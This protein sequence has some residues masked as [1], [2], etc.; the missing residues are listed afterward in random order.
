MLV[1]LHK[2]RVVMICLLHRWY[3]KN[4]PER[5]IMLLA[6]LFAIPY[7]LIA[8]N[9]GPVYNR[10]RDTN[11]VSELIYPKLVNSFYEL[12]GNHLFWFLS[13]TNSFSLRQL[14]KEKIDSSIN[15]GLKKE[16]Y[17]I[18]EI[19][20]YIY[21]NFLPADSITATRIEWIFTDAAIAY[22]KD[23]YQGNDIDQWILSDELSSKQE[24]EDNKF[25]LKELS[26]VNSPEDLLVLFNL[27]E[28]CDV[29]YQ[30]IKKELQFKRDS[31]TS[32]QKKQITTSLQVYRWMHHFKFEKW[33]IVNIASATLRYY[34]YDSIKLRMKAVVGKPST[35]TP[36]IATY[37][38]Y[39]ILYP[40]WNVPASIALNELLPEFKANPED[41]DAL[42]MQV[43][44]LKGNIVDHHK[45][46][47][48]NYNRNYFPF[49][50]R[51]STGCDNSLGV[52]KFNLT[53]PFSVYLHDTNNKAAFLSGYRY[54]SHGCIRIEEPIEL[55][56]E[57]LPDK[58]DSNFLISCLK[59]QQPVA[60]K[61]DNPI[62]VFV[63]YQTVE[64][65]ASGKL[66]YNKDVYGLLK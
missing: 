20:K 42:N 17:H 10:S 5:S 30:T 65:N 34:G 33:I 40:Y 15:S 32:L 29:E 58:L 9:D 16:K 19:G 12:R 52:M 50:I 22:C 51:Q 45:L 26:N 14:L 44:D 48:K 2:W 57:V 11:S 18:T 38:N 31:L 25:L 36:R 47:W 60:I 55:A 41:V 64:T 3:L 28:P 24:T 43:L 23:M 54:Y 66:Q 39:T 61:I 53:S 56:N 37:C 7:C 35:K 13:D 46:N 59:D 49:R 63:I 4:I 1:F 27:L 6:I 21:K 8:R 62:P